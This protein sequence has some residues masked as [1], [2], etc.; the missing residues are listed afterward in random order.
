MNA[1]NQSQFDE[2][3]DEGIELSIP[4][5]FE[6]LLTTPARFKIMYGGRGG[7]KTEN[8]ARALLIFSSQRRLRVA[9]FRELQN[10]LDESVYAT[11]VNCIKD[12]WKDGSW[13]FEWDIQKTT[14]ISKR[15][16]SEFIFSGLRYKIESVK[17]M[18]RIDIAWVEEARNCSKTTLD[19]LFPTIR[20][21]YKD[22]ETGGPF[23]KGPEI[24]L[25]FNP[26][27]ESDEIYKRAI[28]ETNKY[29]PEYIENEE[30]GEKE[31]YAIVTKI[32]YQD[33]PFLPLDMKQQIQVARQASKEDADDDEY[34][35]IWEG[36]T[37]LV[38]AGA[39]Y[40]KE[41]KKVIQE[42]RR[43]RV[44]YNPNKPVFTFW[45]LGHSDKTAIWFVQHAGVEFNII[46][47]YENS[48]EKMP[49]YI[50]YL[51]DTGYN[52]TKHVLPHD[53]DAETLS[54][55]TPK[56][57]LQDAFPNCT[58]RIVKR[59]SKKAVGINAVRTILDLCNFDEE[60]TSEGW[61]CLCNYAYKVNEKK[62]G[63]F[64]REPDHDTPWSHGADA[65][66]T[67]ALSLKPEKEMNKPKTVGSNIKTLHNFR[68][69]TGWMS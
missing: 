59:P 58:V 49:H 47:Y 35:H 16:G 4:K 51:Q 43:G 24:W 15:T 18:A 32:N 26:E 25:S 22:G 48:L 40:K 29:F 39:V 17:S 31:R 56:K 41:I 2:G 50:K 55:V 14:I 45:D 68:S 38:L 60:N 62:E 57:Q 6:F 52:F 10:S 28:K 20:G 23:G 8:I 69:G 1:V 11:L 34:L 64:S 33:N 46:R 19:K 13:V 63:V 37:K 3:T 66:Q 44:P 54:N 5:K 53:G 7:G 12:I 27:L 67:F 36:H 61:A 42:N 30:T 9:C 65:M 21:V